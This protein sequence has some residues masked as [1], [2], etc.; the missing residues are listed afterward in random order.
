MAPVQG[1]TKGWGSLSRAAQTREHDQQKAA[2]A[3]E[4]NMS[5]PG[6]AE[7]YPYGQIKGNTTIKALAVAVKSRWICEQAHQQLK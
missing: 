4:T 7:S 2:P 3:D 6:A 5:V 1:R